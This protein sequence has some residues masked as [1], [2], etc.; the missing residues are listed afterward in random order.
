VA[1]CSNGD[2]ESER[3]VPWPGALTRLLGCTMFLEVS[4]KQSRELIHLECC[5][6]YLTSNVVF[7]SHLACVHSLSQKALACLLSH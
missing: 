2:L 3:G 4:S 6:Q 5:V 7:L 1:E